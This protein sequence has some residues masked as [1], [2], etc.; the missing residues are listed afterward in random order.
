MVGRNVDRCAITCGCLFAGFALV[1]YDRPQPKAFPASCPVCNETKKMAWG[2]VENLNRQI[3]SYHLPE[4][5][6]TLKRK[7]PQEPWVFEVS[8][9]LDGKLCA[10]KQLSGDTGTFSQ[11]LALTI[12]HW[13]FTAF[14][15]R[16]GPAC[17]QT[18]VFF[19]IRERKG[20]VKI[21]IP[22]VTSP[23]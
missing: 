8:L 5:P 13:T 20:Q 21:E 11:L 16:F 3:T 23:I 18:Q 7:I 17:Y 22:G 15:T 4:V 14:Q 6:D 2:G 1:A 9:N 19:Y 10:V 12:R